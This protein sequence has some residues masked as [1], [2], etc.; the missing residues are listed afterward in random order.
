MEAVLSAGQ[1]ICKAATTVILSDDSAKLICDHPITQYALPVLGIGIAI[2]SLYGA[3]RVGKHVYYGLTDRGLVYNAQVGN[4]KAIKHAIATKQ[5]LNTQ[6]AQGNTPLHA[7]LQ[8]QHFGVVKAILEAGARLDV[9]NQKGETALHVAC[10]QNC[11]ESVGLLLEKGADALAK[12]REENSPLMCAA[13]R[14]F[15]RNVEKLLEV[16]GVEIDGQNKQGKTALNLAASEHAEVVK[17]LLAKEADAD[18]PDKEGQIPLHRAAFQENLESLQALL[19]KTKNPNHQDKEGNTA[20]ILTANHESSRLKSA[21]MLLA[22][23]HIDPDLR[24]KEGDSALHLA[25]YNMTTKNDLALLMI[26]SKRFN[27]NLPTVNEDPAA[28]GYKANTAAHIAVIAGDSAMVKALAEGGADFLVPNREG[29]NAFQLAGELGKGDCLSAMVQNLPTEALQQFRQDGLSLIEWATINCQPGIES[30]LNEKGIYFKF[31]GADRERI[32]QCALEAAF[33]KMKWQLENFPLQIKEC[34]EFL[35]DVENLLKDPQAKMQQPELVALFKQEVKTMLK[36]RALVAMHKENNTHVPFADL[37]FGATGYTNNW[38]FK[39]L[40]PMLPE[41]LRT[42]FNEFINKPFPRAEFINLLP[43]GARVFFER[44]LTLSEIHD[45]LPVLLGALNAAIPALARRV[46]GGGFG[47]M[48]G[49]GG[50]DPDD[51]LA[52][53]VA[54]GAPGRAAAFRVV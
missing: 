40:F 22:C 6:D 42:K 46:M 30:M 17:A 24:N 2:V 12:D 28:E 18:I 53:M 39:S 50:M 11:P 21:A 41:A 1:Q 25:C 31:E 51:R 20:L 5:D 3:G 49:L 23:E 35:E 33:K 47:R 54:M 45:Q 13:Q 29:K 19:E 8:N 44:E 15:V 26:R 14:G 9:V 34:R 16:D 7:A 52:A 38:Y 10:Q 27:L 43:A 4:L 32:M 48:A 36:N 37:L